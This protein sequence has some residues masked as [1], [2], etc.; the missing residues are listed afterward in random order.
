M[1]NF[2]LMIQSRYL[3]SLF[4]A[5]HRVALACQ[6]RRNSLKNQPSFILGLIS[7]CL[8]QLEQKMC[9]VKRDFFYYKAGHVPIYFLL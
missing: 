6:Q 2:I 7:R 3:V 1:V 4:L 5:A 8:K 9:H